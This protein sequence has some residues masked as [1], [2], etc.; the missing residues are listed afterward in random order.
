MAT[1][2][3]NWTREELIV[4]FNLYCKIPFSKINYNHKMVIELAN[5]IGRTPSAVAWKLVNF[6]SLDPSLKERHIKGAS[7]AGKLDKVIFEEF[8]QDWNTLAYESEIS[9]A[10]L[11]KKP[12]QIEE[13]IDFEIKEGKVR[14]ALVK[15]RVNQSFFRSTVLASYENKCCITGISIPEFIVA[16]H[17]IPW[18]KDEK[19]R[20]NPE[21]GLCLN[22][23][24]DKAFDKGFITID[25]DYKIKVSK[26]LN[27]FKKENNIQ[28]FFLDF[29][30]KKI[31][32]PKRFLPNKDFLEYHHNNI[33]RK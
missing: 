33:F 14:E 23:I 13:E 31:E 28:K 7:N 15:V 30:N 21:N 32:M 22:S 20:L 26:Y 18:S 6:A 24:H 5:A 17:I 2:R 10:N 3:R 27:D 1:E 11:L 29:E 9:L 12:I 4:A 19:N 16:S 25:F 8:Y